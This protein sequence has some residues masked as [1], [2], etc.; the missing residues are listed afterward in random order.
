MFTIV[1]HLLQKCFHLTNFII[2]NCK[3][4]NK[5]KKYLYT[6]LI[7]AFPRGNLV[8]KKLIRMLTKSSCRTTK[9]SFIQLKL[10]LSNIKV[11]V[12]ITNIVQT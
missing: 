12:S 5:S 7:R 9:L 6:G 2:K 1:G 8:F 11:I 3:S 4:N 10:E